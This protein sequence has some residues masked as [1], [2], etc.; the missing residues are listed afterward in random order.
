MRAKVEIEL[1]FVNP[2]NES[3]DQKQKWANE[4]FVSN[5]HLESRNKFETSKEFAENHQRTG[6][7]KSTRN[8]FLVFQITSII[9]FL[10]ILTILILESSK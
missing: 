3:G 7:H 9:M 8:L 5:R 4:P 6:Y 10:F 1:G 2:R